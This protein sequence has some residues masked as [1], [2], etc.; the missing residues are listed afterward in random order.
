MTWGLTGSSG[1]AAREQPTALPARGL[2]Q[3]SFWRVGS[4]ADLQQER[5]SH[6]PT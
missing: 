2:T 6:C 3:D 5:I 4:L 1:N